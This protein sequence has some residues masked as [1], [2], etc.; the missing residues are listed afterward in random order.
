[1]DINVKKTRFM[2]FIMLTALAG[3]ATAAD[4]FYV[5]FELMQDASVISR[6]N[7]YVT[8]K[9][10][11]W[12]KGLKSS[13]LRLR[14]DK[15]VP[16]KL[17]KMFSTVDHYAG[18]RVTHQMVEDMIEVTVFRSVVQNRRVEIHD[19]PKDKCMDLVPI[20]TT[21]TEK[22]SFPARVGTNEPCKF[23]ENMTFR[24]KVQ[25]GGNI[26]MTFNAL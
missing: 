23:G 9:S 1:M 7:D 2:L 12:N 25:S 10:H 4:R 19:L 3:V 16:G 8:R 22:Y 5:S 26:S 6:G 13:Y 15:S 11:A 17:K 20:V 18:L 24:F 21:V 14:C